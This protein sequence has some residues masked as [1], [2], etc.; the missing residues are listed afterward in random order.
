MT[1]KTFTYLMASSLALMQG[2][3]S[4]VSCAV[5]ALVGILYRAKG[6][7]LTSF[8]FPVAIQQMATRLF[9]PFLSV[10]DQSAAPRVTIPTTSGNPAEMAGGYAARGIRQPNDIFANRNRDFEP[11]PEHLMNHVAPSEPNIAAIVEMGFSRERAMAAL[12]EHGDSVDMALNSL[13]AQD[14]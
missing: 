10:T 8:R 5:G 1:E 6:V 14:E 7:G 2:G 3:S 11:I 13:V 9:R 4:T 12:S